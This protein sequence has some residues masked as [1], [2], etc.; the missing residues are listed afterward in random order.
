MYRI[1]NSCTR[2]I[3]DNG[4]LWVCEINDDLQW[5]YFCNWYNVD[6]D[7][8]YLFYKNAPTTSFCLRDIDDTL[9]ILTSYE[10]EKWL[11]GKEISIQN[12]TIST[13]HIDNLEYEFS[14]DLIWKTFNTI[15]R[16]ISFVMAVKEAEKFYSDSVH[17][18]KVVNLLHNTEINM[19]ELIITEL[20]FLATKN[21]LF[22]KYSCGK[23]TSNN[24]CCHRKIPYVY[25]KNLYKN[26]LKCNIIK[27]ID[28][29]IEC[30]SSHQIAVLYHTYLLEKYDFLPPHYTIYQALQYN[31]SWKALIQYNTITL[32]SEMFKKSKFYQNV[33]LICEHL[34]CKHGRD[35]GSKHDISLMSIF[36][37]WSLLRH[38][39]DYYRILA[40]EKSSENFHY[41]K[42]HTVFPYEIL[43]LLKEWSYMNKYGKFEKD[44]FCFGFLIAFGKLNY[45]RA[46]YGMS[47]KCLTYPK[48]IYT[49]EPFTRNIPTDFLKETAVIFEKID[50]HFCYIYVKIL[51]RVCIK[52]TPMPIYH[53]I[54]ECDHFI[55][56]PR[57]PINA[58]KTIEEHVQ[59]YTLLKYQAISNIK[60][61]LYMKNITS[62]ESYLP[63]KMYNEYFSYI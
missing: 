4:N 61:Y 21:L 22:D 51:D 42:T 30:I 36:D 34:P 62:I 1:R 50:D 7:K 58:C 29:S 52:S 41:I 33:I 23:K 20:C 48:F 56:F 9:K 14:L 18:S 54:Q 46:K 44:N 6:T 11:S 47:Q 2:A 19:D 59:K 57:V 25:F 31:K 13:Y 17:Q 45:I 35:N 40:Y 12:H 3:F 16:D 8:I 24:N 63:S 53:C 32:I 15:H 28:Q 55:H 38:G 26:I 5:A 27:L 10:S 49:D 37:E 60:K 43:K 39:I